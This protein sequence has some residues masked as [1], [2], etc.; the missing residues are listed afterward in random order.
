M[1]EVSFELR[2]VFVEL[3]R[4]DVFFFFFLEVVLHFIIPYYFHLAISRQ[5]PLKGDIGL[6]LFA[7]LVDRL[8]QYPIQM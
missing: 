8:S 3:Q 6:L 2:I 7:F 5:L 1:N 4:R